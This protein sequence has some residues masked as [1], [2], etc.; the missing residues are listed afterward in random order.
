MPCPL[1]GETVLARGRAAGPG[2]KGANQ[3]VAAAR[4]GA[5]T[6]LLAAVGADTGAQLLRDEL[7]GAGVQLSA[8]RTAAQPTGTA[9]VMVDAH[10]E[11][12][13]VVDAG[14]NAALV[15]LTA[16][17]LDV[18]RAARVLL[19]QL[20][21][22]VETVTTAVAAAAGLTVLNAAPA[23]ALPPELTAQLDVLVV[24]E[25]E[26]LDVAGGAAP[27]LEAA[28]SQLLDRVPEVVV[29]VVALLLVLLVRAARARG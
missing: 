27:T 29:A 4:S 1:P 3:A 6:A 18:V 21:V 13:I 23:R 5:R 12:A 20:E 11:N 17:E 9:Y 14:A 19:C 10:G 16:A 22:P 24:N 26:A 15:D 28:L 7:G 25:H 2:G 8:L